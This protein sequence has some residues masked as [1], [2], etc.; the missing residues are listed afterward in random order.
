MTDDVVG[1]SERKYF[2]WLSNLLKDG[3]F[4][5][6]VTVERK[7][8]AFLRALLDL[9]PEYEC[10]WEW[11]KVLSSDAIP[12]LPRGYLDGRK[13]LVFNEM[14]HR[15][16]STRLAVEA[17]QNNLLSLAPE[18]ATAALVVHEDFPK[19]CGS[20][21]PSSQNPSPPDYALEWYVK[22]PSYLEHRSRIITILKRKGALLLDTEH[23]ESIFS[24]EL[25]P[26]ELIDAL[27]TFG[28]PVVF[29]NGSG[30]FPGVTVRTPATPILDEI[31]KKLPLGAKVDERVPQK[32][33]LVRRGPSEFA[34]MPI[35]YP[36]IP[37]RP[38]GEKPSW[39]N[40]PSYLGRSLQECPEGMK[41]ELEFHLASLVTGIELLRCVWAG[42]RPYVL[43]KRKPIKPRSFME[44][45]G[46]GSPLG[47]LRALFPLLDFEGLSV[48]LCSAEL[49]WKD[50]TLSK[51]VLSATSWKKPS[52]KRA[53]PRLYS[54]PNP[55]GPAACR[56]LLTEIVLRRRRYLVGEDWNDVETDREPLVFPW[57]H[58]WSVGADLDIPEQVRSVAMD[59]AIDD[60]VLKTSHMLL[61]ERDSEAFIVRS[62]EPDSEYA[63]DGLERLASG[64]EPLPGDYAS[65]HHSEAV[66]DW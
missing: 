10:G 13:I 12:F 54:V 22:E 38:V 7:A 36:P 41:P 42:L 18:I 53:S 46:V 45:T 5:L 62:Y 50:S 14:V 25:A 11:G 58:F 27:R 64:A 40:P 21:H 61:A 26:T 52:P 66:A 32:V 20:D 43:A 63:R 15:G 59:M 60:A 44:N 48:E 35:W 23:V 19:E 4:D 39:P 47:H 2:E 1:L 28:E 8:T 31:L 55:D 3:D 56:A 33:R 65:F 24:T 57:S 16:G 34:L 6:L 9:C 17:I 37:A 49:G 29:Q 30:D 51:K